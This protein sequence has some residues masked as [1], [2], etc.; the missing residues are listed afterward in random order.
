MTPFTI[1]LRSLAR[2]LGL[3]R[4]YN[5][6]RPQR[7]YED[8]FRQ[9]LEQA[10]RPGDRVWDVGANVGLYTELFAQWTGSNGRV[11]AFEPLPD[12]MH[13]VRA[14]VAAYPNILFEQSALSDTDTQ[15]HFALTADSTTHHIATVDSSAQTI[16]ITI[17]RGDT[18][19]ARLGTPNVIKI[20]VEGFEQEVL[21]GLDQTLTSPALR[22]VLVEVHFRVLEERGRPNAPVEIEKLLLSKNFRTT[23]LDASHLRASR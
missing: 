18:V 9:G 14:R 23:W 8:R 13:Q 10:V 22:E 7:A 1:K 4:V 11:V 5:R 2:S 15:G 16:P 3:I 6:L 17:H 21:R 20:D 12:S 19:A